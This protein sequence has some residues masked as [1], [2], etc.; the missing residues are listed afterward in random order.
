MPLGNYPPLMLTLGY[1]QGVQVWIIPATGEAQEVLAWR[2]GQVKTLKCLPTPE[3]CFG[4]PDNFAH[5]R[6]LV[7][8][9]D[10]TG[11]GS[12]FTSASFISLKSGECVH[13]IKFNSEVADVLVN[14]RVVIMTFREKLAAFDAC[15]L[16]PRF[17]VTTCYPSPGVH[18]NPIALGERWLAYADQQFVAIHRSLG[19]MIVDGGQSVAAWGINVGSKLAQGV[20]K[21]YSNIFS[22]K[23]S[24]PSSCHPSIPPSSCSTSGMDIK[25]RG[26]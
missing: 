7:V 9:V 18:I 11:P 26:I 13:N 16:E 1:T 6:P 12:A 17:T 3:N 20:S 23:T 24:T 4:S 8:M 25:T 2:Q 14:R 19:G 10:T 21:L 22:T 5:C 15:N